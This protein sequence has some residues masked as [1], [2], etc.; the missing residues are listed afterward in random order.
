MESSDAG[1]WFEY[2]H[3]V[4]FADTNMVGNV[5]FATYVLWM[6]KC[7]DMIMAEHYPEI[8][9]HIRNGFGFA[10]EY[11]HMDYLHETFLF[12][13]VVVRMMVKDITR[14]RVEFLCEIVNSATNMVHARGTQAVVWV[15]TQHQ[16]SLMPDELYEKACEYFEL[17]MQ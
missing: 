15:N 7:R 11:A 17:P 12:D 1:K 2:H 4:T 6:G 10:T 16:P 13:E 8:Q 3:R 14:T 9:D 5:Y